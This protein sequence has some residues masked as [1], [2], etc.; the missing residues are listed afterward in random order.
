[1]TRTRSGPLAL[2]LA[3]F[4]F[5]VLA[6][7]VLTGAPSPAEKKSA[8]KRSRKGKVPSPGKQLLQA[9]KNLLRTKS[10][11]TS[12]KVEG[13]L[14][15]TPDHKLFQ[16]AV[17]ESYDGKIYRKLMHVPS[18][19][20]FKTSKKGVRYYSGNW[21]SVLADK[22][23]KILHSFFE[24]PQDVLKQ[25]LRHAKN[26]KWID[27]P[28]AEVNESDDADEDGDESDAASDKPRGK[29]KTIVAKKG[30]KKSGKVA[31]LSSMPRVLVIT[32]PPKEALS[33]YL[34]VENSGCLG[35]G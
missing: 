7:P 21:R 26:G 5:S 18:M 30:K 32:A 33:H 24:F 8:S 11:S 1:M 35:G 20:T 27:T 9:Y 10:Y 12:L 25:A 29:G 31:D 16:L 3:A 2:L 15:N 13:G 23:G 28:R 34:K 4:V 19:K 14:S 6:G 17:R 22:E